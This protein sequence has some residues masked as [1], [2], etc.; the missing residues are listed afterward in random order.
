MLE[1]F[2]GWF[3]LIIAVMFVK[4][5]ALKLWVAFTWKVFGW[6]PKLIHEEVLD[7]AA[8]HCAKVAAWKMVPDDKEHPD[9]ADFRNQ[10]Q[11][12][13]EEYTRWAIE[14]YLYNYLTM[15]QMLIAK[16]RLPD[17][18]ALVAA[19]SEHAA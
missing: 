18:D 13:L 17:P 9:A 1:F 15:G 10:M 11:Q 7:T 3:V 14:H 12:D 19:A 8:K 5:L 2:V 4:L 6:K 16:K